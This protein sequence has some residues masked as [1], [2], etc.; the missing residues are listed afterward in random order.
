MIKP[1]KLGFKIIIVFSMLGI[2]IQ[3]YLFKESYVET[4]QGNIPVLLS[5]PH[6]GSLKPANLKLRTGNDFKVEADSYTLE[7]LKETEKELKLIWGS[8]YLVYSNLH[9]SKI[10]FNRNWL[11]GT[12]STKSLLPI[13]NK[14]HNFIKETELNVKEPLLLIDIHGHKHSE[15]LIELGYGFPISEKRNPELFDSKSFGHLLN[16][17]YGS[18]VAYPP[19]KVKPLLYF[20]GGYITE[21]KYKNNSIHIQVELP[22]NMRSK[23]KQRNII[24]KI[25]AKTI[26]DYY[27][28]SIR[29]NRK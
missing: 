10:D 26:K 22:Q 11:E 19:N 29:K 17:N 2:F 1:L 7:I 12:D 23:H 4:K 13:Y 14:Y 27:N 28:V 16:K 20:D 6:G 18:P 5:A 25:L 3:T 24:A 15:N 8:P 9:R 21:T